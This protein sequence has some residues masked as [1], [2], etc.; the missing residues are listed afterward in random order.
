MGNFG[1]LIFIRRREVATAEALINNNQMKSKFK[2][3]GCIVP[4]GVGQV[5]HKKILHA[6]GWSYREVAKEFG[7]SRT[8]I[9]RVLNSDRTSRSLLERIE[10]LPQRKESAR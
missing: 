9:D 3:R 2:P 4:N 8:H 7:L 6:R 5:K 1:K 10:S